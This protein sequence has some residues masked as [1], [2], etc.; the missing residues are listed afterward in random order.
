[1]HTAMAQYQTS[2]VQRDPNCYEKQGQ[3]PNLSIYNNKIQE[4][5]SVLL[6]KYTIHIDWSITLEF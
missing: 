3:K 1:M 4:V 2:G 5:H 6:M